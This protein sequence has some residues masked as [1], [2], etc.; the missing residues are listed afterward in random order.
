MAW[1]NEDGIHEGWDAAEFDRDRFS[2]GSGG[3]GAWARQFAAGP[4]P[5]QREG[6]PETVDGRTAIG[7]RSMCECGWRGQ[8]W[9][10][11]ATP[12]EH[13]GRGTAGQS[14]A[15]RKILFLVVAVSWSNAKGS[16]GQ[17][18]LK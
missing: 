5:L 9:E 10:R 1:T 14:L 4:G 16:G 12:G 18:P 8:L 17:S 7:W 2:V 11:V 6:E 15:V 3:G 13:R